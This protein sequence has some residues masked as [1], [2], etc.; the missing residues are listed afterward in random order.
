[1]RADGIP[2]LKELLKHSDAKT[3]E[4]AAAAIDA[5]KSKNHHY[6]GERSHSGMSFWTVNPEDSAKEC[7]SRP[8]TARHS[9]LFEALTMIQ[10]IFTERDL[11]NAAWTNLRPRRSIAIVGVVLVVLFFWALWIA[12]F[13]FRRFEPDWMRWLMLGAPAYLAWTFAVWLPRKVRKT[14]RQRKDLQRPCIYRPSDTGLGAE[15]EGAA[16]VKPWTDYLKWKEGRSVFLLYMSD[17]MYQIVPK[18]FFSSEDDLLKF[19][20]LLR[21]KIVRHEA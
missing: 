7:G 6:F 10:G 9:S 16:G 13:G 11:R 17:D 5:I 8:E 4:D 21:E 19:K 14:Y 12:F 2:H 1:L 3:V 15:T 20:N 18:H